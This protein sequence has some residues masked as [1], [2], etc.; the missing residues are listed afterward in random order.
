[1][2]IN[3]IKYDKELILDFDKSIKNKIQ[4]IEEKYADVI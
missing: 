4:E 1:M 2:S 3:Q